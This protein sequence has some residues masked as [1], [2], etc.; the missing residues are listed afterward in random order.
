VPA[1]TTEPLDEFLRGIVVALQRAVDQGIRNA[2][3]T[4]T[5][6]RTLGD[7]KEILDVI[8]AGHVQEWISP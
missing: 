5:A 1:P 7:C 8:M 2:N 6:E 3:D 4:A